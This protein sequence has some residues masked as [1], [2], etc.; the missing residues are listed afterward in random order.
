MSEPVPPPPAGNRETGR[1]LVAELLAFFSS[2]C[3]HVQSLFALAGL[4]AREAAGFYAKLLAIAVAAIVFAVFGY[5]LLIFFLA[6]LIAM[7]GVSWIW[8]T[9]GFALLHL[10]AAV[11]CVLYL[12]ANIQKPVFAS[13]GAEVRKDLEALKN[14]KP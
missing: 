5:F 9:L 10:G 3:Q 12:K 4:E 6:F 14:F 8:I 2:L 13:T 1:G 7:L 11:G